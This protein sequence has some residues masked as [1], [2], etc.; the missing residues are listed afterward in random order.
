MN[1]MNQGY[2][3][4]WMSLFRCNVGKCLSKW[5]VVQLARWMSCVCQCRSGVELLIEMFFLTA[6]PQLRTMPQNAP[7]TV[8]YPLAFK[9]SSGTF[10]LS[11]C[12]YTSGCIFS[13]A[14]QIVK[15]KPFIWRCTAGQHQ[16]QIGC[17]ISNRL[18]H[19][20]TFFPAQLL[21]AFRF[22]VAVLFPDQLF[23]LK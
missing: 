19:N 8:T 18:N 6:F 1:T 20:R 23:P 3:Q 7:L 13:S 16:T 15:L 2:S 22:C 14:N 21:R 10:C 17:R 11:E 9:K 4:Y 12:S 5:M